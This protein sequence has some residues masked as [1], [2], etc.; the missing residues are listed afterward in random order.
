M[1]QLGARPPSLPENGGC[2]FL[3]ILHFGA[4]VLRVAVGAVGD[5]WPTV[6]GEDQS[7]D[8]QSAPAEFR[9]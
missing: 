2:D 6:D 9:G 3:H 5:C 4:P 8:R 1:A 7:R